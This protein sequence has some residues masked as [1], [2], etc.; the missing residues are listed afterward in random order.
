MQPLGKDVPPPY[1][2]L[3]DETHQAQQQYQQPHQQQYQQPH[4][5]Q[6]QQPHQQQYQPPYHHFVPQQPQQ[7]IVVQ[8]T[9]QQGGQSQN[10]QQQQQQSGH[11]VS[12]NCLGC[13]LC[14]TVTF[15]GA[16]ISEL[17]CDPN[18]DEACD[19]STGLGLTIAGAIGTAAVVAAIVRRCLC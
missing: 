15:L 17:A 12:S 9:Q 16:G 2:S 18:N 10:Q 19:P 3:P 8:V 1:S 6:Y 7:P 13:V 5:Q 4:Q 14:I 11:A